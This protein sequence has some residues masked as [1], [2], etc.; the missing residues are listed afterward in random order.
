[1]DALASTGPPKL[2]KLS[3]GQFAELEKGARTGRAWLG[4]PAVDR[5][6]DQSVDRL[7]VRRRLL[8][9]GG[10]AA[11]APAQLVLAVSRAPGR[12]TR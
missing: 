5:G 11:A 1:M 7:E 10:V 4:G 3:D 12:R 8:D 6:A 9:G 2:P